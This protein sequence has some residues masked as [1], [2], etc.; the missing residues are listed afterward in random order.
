MRTIHAAPLLRRTLDDR[1]VADTAVL[2]T[3]D[4]IEAVAPA[5]ELTAAYPGVRV[6]RWPGVLGPALVHDGPLP[7]AP[8]PRERVHALFGL[9]AAAALA[10]QVTDPGL[11]AAAA[12]NGVALLASARPPALV[13]GGRADL[14]V[15]ADDGSCVATVVAG[16]LVHRRA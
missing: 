10:D 6:R 1:P 2:V 7:P 13:T 15:F 11:R 16:R 14:A 9:G 8:T 5:G 4:R 12:R 3:G